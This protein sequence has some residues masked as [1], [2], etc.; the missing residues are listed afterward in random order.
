MTP[1]P[2][3]ELASSSTHLELHALNVKCAYSVIPEQLHTHALDY[4]N[5][6]KE[7]IAALCLQSVQAISPAHA[8][9]PFCWTVKGDT[10]TCN[11]W[12]LAR[13]ASDDESNLCLCYTELSLLRMDYKFCPKLRTAIIKKT[14]LIEGVLNGLA[15]L[16][17]VVA[18]GA[19]RDDVVRTPFPTSGQLKIS[20]MS[21]HSIFKFYAKTLELYPQVLRSTKGF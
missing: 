7:E 11:G 10:H 8:R 4:E 3:V 15:F 16:S 19:V 12:H 9:C 1:R 2:D 21:L 14:R 18:A 6:S 17:H 20:P 13:V 5:P